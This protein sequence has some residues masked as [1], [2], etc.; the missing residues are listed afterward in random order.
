MDFILKQEKIKKM[1]FILKQKRL[2]NTQIAYAID[3][4]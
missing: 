2:K 4:H 3:R 1:D